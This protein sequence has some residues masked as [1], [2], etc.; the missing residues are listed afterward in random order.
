MT[1]ATITFHA[2]H[3]Y[4]SM[5]QAYALQ[6]TLGR[7]GFDNEIINLRTPRQR[8]MYG[9]VSHCPES[10]AKNL[11][12]RVMAAPFMGGLRK[13]Y[14][15]FEKFL[16]DNLKLTKEYDSLEELKRADLRYDCFISGGDQ[17]WNTAPTDFDWSYYLPFV[18]EGIRISYAVSMGPRSREQVT[19]R[20]TVRKYLS[21][22]D[23]ISVREE[24]TRKLVEELT[25]KKAE[26]VLDPVLLLEPEEWDKHL[27][28]NPIIKGDYILLYTPGFNKETFDAASKIR[29]IT[30]LPVINTIFKPQSLLYPDI[31]HKFDVGPWEFLN[32]LKYSKMVVSGSYHAVIFSMLYDK[33]FIAVNGARDNRMRTMLENTG[34]LGQAIPSDSINQDTLSPC[35]FTRANVYIRQERTKSVEFLK[36][37]IIN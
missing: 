19:E 10:G 8:A 7:L 1:T 32:L 12:R 21:A 2:P 30:H 28:P 15:L 24:E 17:I 9:P 27:D 33:D 25:G 11:V 18:K 35:D 26:L 3:N 31:K 36:N 5:L 37:A 22:Y 6:Y 14:G 34:L 23:H 13:R 29:R 20:E 4:G 16:Q